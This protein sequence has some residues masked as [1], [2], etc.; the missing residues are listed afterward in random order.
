MTKQQILD[1]VTKMVGSCAAAIDV[2]NRTGI[3][4]PSRRPT[5]RDEL[6]RIIIND[7]NNADAARIA[8][9]G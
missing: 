9:N 2:I 8:A 3:N 1:E 6:E 7:I 4:K 5:T